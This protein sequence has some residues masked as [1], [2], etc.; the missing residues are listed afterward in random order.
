[1]SKYGY[2]RDVTSP[3]RPREAIWDQLSASYVVISC[4]RRQNSRPG[5]WPVSAGHSIVSC[6]ESGRL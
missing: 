4:S 5:R 3:F 1:V 2:K 6:I